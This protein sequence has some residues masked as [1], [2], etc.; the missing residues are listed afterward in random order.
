[1]LNSFALEKAGIPRDAYNICGDDN[2]ALATEREINEFERIIEQELNMLMNKD[3]SFRSRHSGVFCERLMTTTIE[4]GV[5]RC[6]GIPEMRLGEACAARA[7][8]KQRGL[9]AVDTLRACASKDKA[10]HK[11][12]WISANAESLAGKVDGPIKNG[13]RGSGKNTELTTLKY[14]LFGQTATL[15]VHTNWRVKDLFEAA[16]NIP[17]AK[18]DTIRLSLLKATIHELV[19]DELRRSQR[20][21]SLKP[22]N[23]SRS[24]TIG[25]FRAQE[26]EVIQLRESYSMERFVRAYMEYHVNG[27]EPVAHADRIKHSEL[28]YAH[29]S[30]R[31]AHTLIYLCKE[32]KWGA[33][34]NRIRQWTERGID[35]VVAREFLKEH[36]FE[37]E[38][39]TLT[40]DG[41]RA[42][43]FS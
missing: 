33:V 42:T 1:M 43:R 14:V 29:M 17:A 39:Y 30:W 21:P 27:T 41:R 6:R 18:G 32:K 36:G 35:K 38:Q 8:N 3:K 40:L 4:N 34:I 22:L 15:K 19:E 23:L 25:T 12:A 37:V 20:K 5:F 13:G 24:E 31:K 2:I 7:C 10:L 28:K 26:K 16:N 9:S 11:L